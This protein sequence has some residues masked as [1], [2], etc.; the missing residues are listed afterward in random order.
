MALN[1]QSTIWLGELLSGRT[2]KEHSWDSPLTPRGLRNSTLAI[3][4]RTARRVNPL[5]RRGLLNNRQEA[6]AVAGRA[7]ILNYV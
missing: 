2:H 6:G 4:L 1:S 5:T 7:Y 3:A